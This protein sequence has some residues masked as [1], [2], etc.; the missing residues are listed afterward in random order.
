MPVF[1]G[2]GTSSFMKDADGVGM[3]TATTTTRNAI[4]GPRPGQMLFNH[5]TNLMEY[6]NGTAWIAIDSPPN[7]SS[8][9]P[10]DV[11]SNAGGNV[12]F[13]ITGERFGI[14][15][16]VGFGTSAFFKDEASIF[17]GDADDFELFHDGSDSVIRN[18]TGDLKLL[19]KLVSTN[20]N[21]TTI[22]GID[23]I[24]ILKNN[25]LFLTNSNI[26]L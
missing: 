3:S 6:Y 2:A 20:K 18:R 25:S 11:D 19:I 4:S 14:G 5:T 23:E 12:T 13:T 22:T 9:S 26:S 21:P 15:A 8:V 1:V 10:T 24:N 17:M 16:T 7:V